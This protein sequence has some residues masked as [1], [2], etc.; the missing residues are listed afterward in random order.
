LRAAPPIRPPADRVRPVA[1]R[2]L[3]ERRPAPSRPAPRP[4]RPTAPARPDAAAPVPPRPPV[5]GLRPPAPPVA[6]EPATD[7]D[8]RI[9]A[10]RQA[11]RREEDRRRL[12]RAIW[13]AGVVGVALVAA[14][15]TRTPLLDVD[16]VAVAGVERLGPAEV[17]AVLAGAGIHR[18]DPLLEVDLG[19]ARAALEALP[20]V[21]E[22]DVERRWPGTIVVAVVERT[23]VAAVAVA[24]GAALVGADGIVVAVTDPASPTDLAG[25]VPVVGPADLAPGDR[26]DAPELLGVAAAIPEV[27]RPLVAAVGPGDGDGAVELAL[28][29][30]GVIRLGAA[31]QLATKLVAAATVLTQVD[32]ACLA[33]VD[34]RVPSAPAVT[35]VPGC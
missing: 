25:T 18:G 30:G 2:P 21:V 13:L 16:R 19:R 9:S 3:V 6:V 15:A 31:D 26:F 27:L 22:A 35:R 17:E 24:G 14:V 28:A 8:P 10:R 32:T 12:R 34:V 7:I 23:P 5:P 4:A 1:E 11:V 29:A 20:G 33:T